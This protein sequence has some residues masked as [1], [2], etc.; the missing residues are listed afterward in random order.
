[1]KVHWGFS[2]VW[3]SCGLRCDGL[4]TAE[5][6]SKVTCKRCLRCAVVKAAMRRAAL[7]RVVSAS[8]TTGG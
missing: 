5:T 2:Y 1:M 8:E 6:P 7:G 3:T 4:A